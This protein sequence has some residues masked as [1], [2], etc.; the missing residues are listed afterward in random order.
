M[1]DFA[2]ASGVFN[3]VLSEGENPDHITRALSA[4]HRL[5]KLAVCV[6]FLTSY[7]DY[8]EPQLWYTDRVGRL[9]WRSLSAVGS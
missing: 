8:R 2:I 6:D 7:A 5:S 3:A 1:H 4:M 9:M